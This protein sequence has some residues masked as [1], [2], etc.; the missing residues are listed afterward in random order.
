MRVQIKGLNEDVLA[1]FVKE[2]HSDQKANI[3]S[4]LKMLS[5]LRTIALGL[6]KNDDEFV[7]SAI[8]VIVATANYVD[9]KDSKP[10]FTFHSFRKRIKLN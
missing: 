9:L 6:K 4:V 7:D 5:G 8:P 1:G 3:D 10:F 2:G